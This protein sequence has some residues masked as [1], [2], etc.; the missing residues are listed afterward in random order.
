MSFASTNELQN[1]PQ[2]YATSE[3]ITMRGVPP[4]TVSNAAWCGQPG[5]GGKRRTVQLMKDAKISAPKPAHTTL[6][7]RA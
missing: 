7:A 1:S 4:K 3:A 5:A 2:K 6:R